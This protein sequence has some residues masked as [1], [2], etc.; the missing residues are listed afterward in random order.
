MKIVNLFYLYGI[1]GA[2]FQL[3]G[4][5]TAVFSDFKM[6]FTSGIFQNNVQYWQNQ[7]SKLISFPYWWDTGD[8][9]GVKYR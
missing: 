9:P 3:S 1:N 8:L 7:H 4:T 6:A 2:G 5:N